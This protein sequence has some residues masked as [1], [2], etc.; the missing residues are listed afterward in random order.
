MIK[1]K[2][3]DL[4]LLGLLIYLCGNYLGNV[5]MVICFCIF[6]LLSFP[7]MFAELKKN[8]HCARWQF[9]FWLYLCI[10]YGWAHKSLMN[11]TIA[12]LEIIIPFSS[13]Y[14]A[15][16]LFNFIRQES[17]IKTVVNVLLAALVFLILY[18]VVV[19]PLDVWGTMKLGQNVGINKNAI[20]LNSAWG[21]VICFYFIKNKENRFYYLLFIIFSVV[22]LISGSRKALVILMV[23]I[24]LYYLFSERN[25]KLLKNIGIAVIILSIVWIAVMNIPV[26]Y[27]QVGARTIT[28]LKTLTTSSSVSISEDKSIW[29]RSYYR[30][31][32]LQMFRE[33]PFY[34]LFGHGLD[35]FR[36]RMAEIGYNHVAYS[37][38]NFTELLANYGL[39][40]F[41]LYYYFKFKV[42][43]K[44]FFIKNRSKLVTLF[45]II[46]GLGI[47]TEYGLVSYYD[48]FTQFCYMLACCVIAKE[49]KLKGEGKFNIEN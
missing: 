17:D 32:A 11:T 41:L 35:G 24:F 47:V 12:A 34:I 20:G 27:E 22:C 21:S 36:T 2:Y 6:V 46:L 33:N 5:E 10:S 31:Y 40:G 39:I 18:L 19:T 44:A 1:L 14:C 43:L 3:R 15:I 45:M 48:V 37:H 9:I 30:R 42:I 38:C 23:G 4:S 26:L 28:M 7:K 8:N 29:E 13:L 16:F 49:I 25:I